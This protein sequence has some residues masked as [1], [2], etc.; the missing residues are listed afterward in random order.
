MVRRLLAVWF[1]LVL[2]GASIGGAQVLVAGGGQW[3]SISSGDYDNLGVDIKA[4]FGLAG[5][6]M[7][8]VGR[9]FRIGASGQWSSHS[10]SLDGVE[11]LNNVSLLG[12]FAEGH[13][14][15]PATG[16]V[17]PYLGIRAGYSRWTYSEGGQDLAASGFAFGGGGGVMIALSPT[18]AL[19]LNGMVHSAANGDID[20]DGTSM[21]GTDATATLVQIR[22]GLC[23][24][25]GGR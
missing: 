8:P 25:L 12:V 2:A 23:F 11:A 4:G 19:D 9:S 24:M 5:S 20:V 3:L 6:V 17:A 1:A 22:A 7:M 15:I 16:Q 10:V 13:Y 21:P 14:E 18:L